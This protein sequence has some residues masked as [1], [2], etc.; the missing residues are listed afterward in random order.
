MIL[1][2]WLGYVVNDSAD[3]QPVIFVDPDGKDVILSPLFSKGEFGKAFNSLKTGSKTFNTLISKYENNSKFNLKLTVNT[4]KVNSNGSAA[5]TE[6]AKGQYDKAPSSLDVTTYFKSTTSVETNYEYTTLGVILVVAHEAL[7]QKIALLPVKEDSDHNKYTS[8][9]TNVFSEY[10]KANNLNLSEGDI[11]DL[12][13]SG[14]QSSKEF[15]SYITDL[16]KNNNSTY[17][18]EKSN[19]DTRVSNLIYQKKD[20]SK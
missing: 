3:L 10:S 12:V 18:K 19:Y 2:R 7:H 15:K 5:F 20:E 13:F 4:Q 17:E 16:A 9:L 14:Q 8:E 11:K 6:Y 1:S